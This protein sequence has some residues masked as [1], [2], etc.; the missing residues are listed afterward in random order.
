MS[1]LLYLQPPQPV[2]QKSSAL[3]AAV[4][5][6]EAEGTSRRHRLSRA[7]PLCGGTGRGGQCG[8]QEA[9]S[10]S[11]G[12]GARRTVPSIRVSSGSREEGPEMRDVP[13]S[14]ALS[15]AFAAV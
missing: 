14:H 13:L 5:R 1:L 12:Q 7:Y 11:S 15:L 10:P 9:N 4:E 8:S 6:L 3:A 2:G